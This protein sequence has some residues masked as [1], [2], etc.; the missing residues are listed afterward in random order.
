MTDSPAPEQAPLGTKLLIGAFSVSGVAHF[1]R[2]EVFYP[3]IP[4]QLG[5]PRAWTYASGA[6]ELV[7]AAG[8]ATRQRWAPQTTAA[9]LSAVWVG[10]WWIAVRASRAPRTSRW[11]KA[12]LWARVPLQVPMITA[13]LKSPV[14]A[15]TST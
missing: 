14:K 3:L 15:P 12:A 9:V 8:L 4:P 1:V 10:N 11:L 2:P 5:S 13:A 7:C 6:A